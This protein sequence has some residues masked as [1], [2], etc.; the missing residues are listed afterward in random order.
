MSD[1]V[2]LKGKPM[3]RAYV[4]LLPILRQIPWDPIR[5]E[6]SVAGAA[7]QQRRTPAPW[8]I[9]SSAAGAGGDAARAATVCDALCYALREMMPRMR[10][11]ACNVA[12][13]ALRIASSSV[14]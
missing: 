11:V 2:P 13:T 14:R 9:L 5:D 8:V 1:A 4:T 3:E 12:S 6:P 7:V 10:F